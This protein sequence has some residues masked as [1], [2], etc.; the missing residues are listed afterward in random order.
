MQAKTLLSVIV[1]F[2]NAARYFSLL[3]NSIELQLTDKVQVVLV[4]DGATDGSLE[5]AQQHM[6]NSATP[7]SYLLLQQ[8]NSGVSVARNNGIAQATGEY[9]GFIDADDLLL[10]G[11]F[12][13]L[14]S[15]IQQHKPDLIELGYKR[16]KD[17]AE[18]NDAKPRYLHRKT[19]WLEKEKA[20]TDVY[21][22]NRWYPW[23][24]VY[25]RSMA[26]NFQFPPGIAFCEDLMSLPSLYQA[27]QQLYH[28]G[29]PLYGYRE[30]DASASFNVKTQHQ[31]Q[32][33]RFFTAVQ[34]KKSYPALPQLWR[35]IFLFH[36][37]Y[38]LYKLELDN[39]SQPSFPGLLAQQLKTLIRQFWWSPHF[40][41]RKKL[42]LAFAPLFFRW[43]RS[44]N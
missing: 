17:S 26:T 41:A 6:I 7:Q 11:Y 3:L 24:R 27:A 33:H 34:Q 30:H 4:C 38:L 9:I 20:I 13:N 37:A 10:P 12:S 43:D 14:L 40:S 15:V 18:L 21:K 5:L 19:G 39:K 2:Y 44:K 35:H 42:N 36:L 29:L 23:L 31:Q 25:R 8:Q 28:L 22:A 32:L 16:F 1:P